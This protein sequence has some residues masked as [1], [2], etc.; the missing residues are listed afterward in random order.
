VREEKP[1]EP[2]NTRNTRKEP[3]AARFLTTEITEIT[4]MG[5][6]RFFDPQIFAV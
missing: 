3:D 4:K 2:R 5:D 1:F 6:K